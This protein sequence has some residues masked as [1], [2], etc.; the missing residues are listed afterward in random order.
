LL[1]SFYSQDI[2]QG[3]EKALDDMIN[4]VY[5]TKLLTS[6]VCT[7][8]AIGLMQTGASG[9]VFRVSTLITKKALHIEEIIKS[10]CNQESGIIFV[11]KVLDPSKK[12]CLLIINKGL[13]QQVIV[14]PNKIQ[15]SESD[16]GVFKICL[17]DN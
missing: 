1:I 15:Y 5:K 6:H 8:I 11:G 16:G 7:H 12:P 9:D 3:F 14:G 2:K 13:Q 10:T 4:S 17:P